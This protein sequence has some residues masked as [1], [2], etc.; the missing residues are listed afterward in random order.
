MIFKEKA[1][2]FGSVTGFCFGHLIHSCLMLGRQLLHFTSDDPT[3]KVA[4]VKILYN[5]VVKV[6]RINSF[7]K[8]NNNNNNSYETAR[9][10][11][12][13][14]LDLVPASANLLVLSTFYSLQILERKY[15]F[16]RASNSVNGSVINAPLDTNCR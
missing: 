11:R 10:C 3:I 5:T 2:N 1:S 9:L 15:K 6:I 16:P 4:Y 14:L 12:H 13:D 8:K 7:E